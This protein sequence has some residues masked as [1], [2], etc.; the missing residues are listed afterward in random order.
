[1][2]SLAANFESSAAFSAGMAG[3]GWVMDFRQLEPGIEDVTVNAA[4]SPELML[5]RAEFCS[6]T[7]Q[8]VLPPRDSVTFGIPTRPQAPGR[9]GRRPLVSESLTC[10]HP[11]N[12]M[13]AVNPPGFSAYTLTVNAERISQLA[14]LAAVSDPASDQGM[15]GLLCNPDPAALA[16]LRT[17][18]HEFFLVTSQSSAKLA[19]N[20]QAAVE[21]DLALEVLQAFAT[22]TP[23][24]Y[25]AASGRSRALK[26]ALALM[27]QSSSEVITVEALCRESACSISTLERA[28]GEQFSVSPKQYLTAVRL[29]GVRQDLQSGG[30]SNVSDLASQWGFWHMSKFAADYKRMFG[31]LPSQTL[32]AAKTPKGKLRT[33]TAP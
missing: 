5:M 27:E 2:Q 14:Q 24:P 21:S 23:Q 33:D 15:H 29:N 18:L 10:F 26:R 28:F 9:M 25:V 17:F 8:Q 7:H 4:I 11:R 30:A 12:G 20:A 19:A 13:D 32:A 22:G 1:M 3:S 16:R 31:E 6:R